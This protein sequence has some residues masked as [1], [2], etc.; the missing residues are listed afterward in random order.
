VSEP[1]GRILRYSE[2]RRLAETGT[3]GDLIHEQ[4]PDVVRQAVYYILFQSK[5][6]QQSNLERRLLDRIAVHFSDFRVDWLADTP[7]NMQLSVDGFLD[8][9]E[10]AIE[11][12]NLI[13][14][15]RRSS[16][17][18]ESIRLLGGLDARLNALF[19]THRFGYRF[20]SGEAQ[21]MD[22][23]LLHIEVVG[24]ALIAS[25]RAGW[26][27]VEERYRSAILHHRG[28]DTAK[29]LTD[30]NAATESALKAVGMRGNATGDLTGAF[31]RSPML[32]PYGD[33]VAGQLKVLTDNLM[34]WRSN[35]GD[36]HGGGP[37]AADAPPELA[38]LA[39]HWAG[40]YIVFL[41]ALATDAT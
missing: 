23:P 2:R 32:A 27:E 25:Q 24:P 19:E 29:A 11:A 21:R 3:L 41:A 12:G 16:G 30:A 26:S 13:V 38:A 9:C 31:R 14:Q 8:Y 4:V 18:Y 20:V 40:A 15:H 28:G 22:S 1:P 7:L 37:G 39:I 10:I 33:R 36:A 17:E 6:A 35:F 34:I 5:N